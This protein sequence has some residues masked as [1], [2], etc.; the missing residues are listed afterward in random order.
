[1]TDSRRPEKE[2]AT[3]R[4]DCA[5]Q[6]LQSDSKF[7]R[8]LKAL[9][10]LPLAGCPVTASAKGNRIQW[11]LSPAQAPVPLRSSN[12]YGPAMFPLSRKYPMAA[13]ATQARLSP[14]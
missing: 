13:V 1:M 2:P 8:L 11:G 3:L 7:R 6:P 9:W 14:A 12:D 10:G 4:S 5:L